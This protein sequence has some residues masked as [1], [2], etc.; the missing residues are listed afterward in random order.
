MRKKRRH[1]KWHENFF[2][3][4]FIALKPLWH[5]FQQTHT[6]NCQMSHF[7]PCCRRCLSNKEDIKLASI[8][9]F[10][11]CMCIKLWLSLVARRAKKRKKRIIVESIR[12]RIE[13]G[14]NMN[15]FC[16]IFNHY[17][18]LAISHRARHTLRRYFSLLFFGV[19]KNTSIR[20]EW[21]EKIFS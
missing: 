4:Y 10:E 8:F 14:K 16:H 21:G 5:I 12:Q 18:I 3:I 6:E 13:N 19:N 1:L 15:I 17:I 2:L 20:M 11:K 9:F 7:S